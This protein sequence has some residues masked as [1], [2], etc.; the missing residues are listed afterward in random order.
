MKTTKRCHQVVLKPECYVLK[1]LRHAKRLSMRSAASLLGKSD[2]YISH[3]ENGRMDIP[4][5]PKLEALLE[6]YLSLIHI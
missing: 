6:I 2:T 1:E 5:G 4:E 3:I